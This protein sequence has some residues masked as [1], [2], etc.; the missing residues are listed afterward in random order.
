MAGTD[1]R[2]S[3]CNL[4]GWGCEAALG[5]SHWA[6]LLVF[7]ACAMAMP[8]A[9]AQ[10]AEDGQWPMP[11]K[12]FQGHRYSGLTELTPENVAELKVAWTFSLG[13]DK[14]QEA[15]PIVADNTMFVVTPYPNIL[16]AIDLTKPGGELK[17][18]LEP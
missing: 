10:E 1:Y 14:G 18:K 5:R 9:V 2:A 6:A 3:R 17:W 16:Y 13:T 12:N 8:C 15:A 7:A 11:G 4:A